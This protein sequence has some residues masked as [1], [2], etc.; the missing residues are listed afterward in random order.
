MGSSKLIVIP[1]AGISP[2]SI[3]C[4]RFR[5]R[6]KYS[7]VLETIRLTLVFGI[8]D[9]PKLMKFL[10]KTHHYGIVRN[11][12]DRLGLSHE[13]PMMIA[14]AVVVS[15]NPAM[16]HAADAPVDIGQVIGNH[17]TFLPPGLILEDAPLA[18]ALEAINLRDKLPDR[19][20]FLGHRYILPQMGF[21]I[22][23]LK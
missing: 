5:A 17:L 19:T 8:F 2:R 14:V 21:Y 23:C 22:S 18:F 13:M 1:D 16:V 15:Q 7:S 4:A 20:R 3:A 12:L 6:S 11:R 10:I 9:P